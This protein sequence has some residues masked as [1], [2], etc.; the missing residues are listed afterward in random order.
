MKS[1]AGE[2][3]VEERRAQ[4]GCGTRRQGPRGR[5]GA[6]EAE[7]SAAGALGRRLRPAAVQEDR[8]AALQ[9]GVRRGAEGAQGG[10]RAPSPARRRKPTFA[11]TIVALEK[12]GRLLEQGRRR[13]LQSRRR[14]HQRGAAGDR[15]RDG[16]EARRARDRDHAQR[17]RSSSASPISTSAATNSTSPTSSAR[18][19]E[20]RY[21]W[22][23]RAGAKLGAKQKARVAEI[24]QRLATLATQF[25]QNVLKDEQSWRLVLEEARPRRPAGGAARRSRA[26]R[27]RPGHPGKY[28]ITLSRSIDRAVPAVLCPPRSARGGVQRLDPARRDGRRDRQP[29]HHRR[30]HRAARRVRR[31]CSASRP[32]PSTASKRRWPRRPTACAI[33]C[34]RC[35]SRP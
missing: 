34:P 23:V 15:A 4:Q 18:V 6:H 24:N 17:A 2:S 19:L 5:T 3:Q 33:C 9:G 31:A 13:L 30:D 35:G 1:K 8:A 21:K 26:R 27:R 28:V 25:S 16:A 12:S 10:D 7:Q 29:R 14:A 11:N 22:L 20:L 32:T